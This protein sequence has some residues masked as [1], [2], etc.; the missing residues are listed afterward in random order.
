MANRSEKNRTLSAETCSDLIV[1]YHDMNRE[2][3]IEQIEEARQTLE[4]TPESSNNASFRRFGAS[5]SMGLNG[6][7]RQ[8]KSLLRIGD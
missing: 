8:L 5:K 6:D 1:K 3:F 7:F 2:A 4:N